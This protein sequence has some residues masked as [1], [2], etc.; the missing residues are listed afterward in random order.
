MIKWWYTYGREPEK[1][2]LKTTIMNPIKFLTTYLRSSKAELLKV[3]WPTREETLRYSGLV[4][5][6]CLITAAYFAALDFG[7]GRGLDALIS[8][9]RPQATSSAPAEAPVTPDVQSGSVNAVD[10]NGNPANVDVQTLPVNGADTRSGTFT[11]SP[12]DSGDTQQ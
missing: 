3:T 8:V 5:A 12:T 2:F 4:A 10:K 9:A 6:V 11:V 7:F 1:G